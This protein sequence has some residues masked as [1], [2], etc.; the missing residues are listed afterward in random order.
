MRAEIL[1]IGSELTS[2]QNPDPNG[3]SLLGG[4]LPLRPGRDGARACFQLW[5]RT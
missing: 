5:L 3:V 4:T 1:S 2:G